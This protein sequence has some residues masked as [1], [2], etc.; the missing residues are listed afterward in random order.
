MKY[1]KQVRTTSMIEKTRECV[2]MK[3]TSFC[4]AKRAENR[5]HVF[6]MPGS[7]LYSTSRVQACVVNTT[8]SN[9]SGG[10]VRRSDGGHL[11]ISGAGGE[12]GGAGYAVAVMPEYNMRISWAI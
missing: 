8:G 12:A 4:T 10:M 1:Q 9:A 3:C 6:L 5:E 7:G 2:G 11:Q